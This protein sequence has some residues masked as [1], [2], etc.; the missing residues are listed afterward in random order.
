MKVSDQKSKKVGGQKL[1]SKHPFLILH[2][3]HEKAGEGLHIGRV[4]LS[5]WQFKRGR[6][7]RMTR[8]L[9]PDQRNNSKSHVRIATVPRSPCARKRG[10]LLWKLWSLSEFCFLWNFLSPSPLR[11]IVPSFVLFHFVY[12]LLSSKR[13]IWFSFRVWTL[14]YVLEFKLLSNPHFQPTSKS[15]VRC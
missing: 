5:L 12:D 13:A 8:S 6:I 2:S 7:N 10:R 15:T 3:P 9:I 1:R 11:S 14:H 4:L